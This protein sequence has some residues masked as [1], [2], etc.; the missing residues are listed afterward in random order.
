MKSMKAENYYTR[1]RIPV[2]ETRKKQVIMDPGTKVMCPQK[3]VVVELKIN[4]SRVGQ[5]LGALERCVGQNSRKDV[6]VE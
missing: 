2:A 1:I 6:V 4:M 3:D 5:K